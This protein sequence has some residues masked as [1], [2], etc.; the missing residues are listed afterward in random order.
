M[1]D[2]TYST[3]IQ[4][5]IALLILE[6]LYSELRSNQKVLIDNTW[7]SG[8]VGGVAGRVLTVLNQRSQWVKMA[9]A[10]ASP[11]EWQHWFVTAV[12]KQ[13]APTLQ[14]QRVTYFRELEAEA[15]NNAIE[16]FMRKDIAY[17]PGADTESFTV[18]TQNIRYFVLGHGLRSTPRVWLPVDM[19]DAQLKRV[20]DNIWNRGNWT[21]RRR[22]CAMV[23]TPVAATGLTYAEAGK[24][25]TGTGAWTDYTH[26]AGA[27]WHTTG[28][29]DAVLAPVQVASRT[30]ANEIVLSSSIGAGAD[31]SI[32][33]AG[34][35]YTVTFIGLGTETFDKIATKRL[36]YQN[37][38]GDLR[39]AD[40]DRMAECLAT[41]G[42]GAGRPSFFRVESRGGST[43]HWTLAP[44]PDTTYTMNVEV[45]VKG[46]GAPSSATDTTPFARFPDAF[47]HVIRDA[48]LAETLDHV[49]HPD[50][51][52]QKAM[53]ESE[54]ERL[55]PAY[56][57]LAESA[58]DVGYFDVYNDGARMIGGP[59]LT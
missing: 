48:V 51:R 55:L 58:A 45:Y 59:N 44:I 32:D 35:L 40:A 21:F 34:T 8:T 49:G 27:T 29:T 39:W 6:K 7:T 46:P 56:S 57:E 31:G 9:N 13:L 28:G 47:Q 4:N 16:S 19:V 42:G 11:A 25:L 5:E 36:Y 53:I 18:T 52:K 30:N 43:P 24:T 22:R 12:C 33:I 20:L 10:T 14:P 37:S 50:G 54:I 3:A 23:I 26:V 2:I 1:A 41:L 15:E 17:S 38:A